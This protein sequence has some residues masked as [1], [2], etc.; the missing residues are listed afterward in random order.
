[1]IE[2]LSLAIEKRWRNRD[3]RWVNP[4]RLF[5]PRG[6]GV[7]PIL[8]R[9]AKPF[10]LA[11]HYSGTFPAARCSIG[12]VHISPTGRRELAGV[13]VFSVPAQ[14][15][16][17]PH[18]TGLPENDGTELGRFV[19][20]DDV[21][22][23]GESWFLARSFRLLREL[24]PN[25]RAI[26]SYADPLER[27]DACS[28]TLYKRAHWGQIYQASNALYAG[29]A[30]ARTLILTPNGSIVS[31]R[32]ISKIRNQE[33][34]H[35]YAERALLAAGAD[36]RAF[37]EDPSAWLDRVLA[38]PTFRRLRHPGN[39]V[40]VFGLD[41]SARTSIR[42]ANPIVQPYPRPQRAVA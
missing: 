2:Q 38:S 42:T 35:D 34:S 21:A 24:K 23:N 22:F 4:D 40:Y 26:V 33:R 6:F 25:I 31:E 18:Y 11:H 32:A 3:E 39:L 17:V 19:C 7:E 10:V 20:V 37:G 27:R 12:L 13:A 29:R 30:T 36:P 41:D 28:G 9:D 14:R 1:M 16:V 5:D 15:A 8:E